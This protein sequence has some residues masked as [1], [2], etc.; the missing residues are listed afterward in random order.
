MSP[1]HTYHTCAN[2]C[3]LHQTQL[4]KTTHNFCVESFQ[5]SS[6]MNLNSPN[7]AL[8][9]GNLIVRIKY[10]LFTYICTGTN[11]FGSIVGSDCPMPCHIICPP[12]YSRR[13]RFDSL[14]IIIINITILYTTAIETSKLR[15]K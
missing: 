6:G 10:G 9:R 15:P 2:F 7:M 4:Q 14:T 1:V 8:L 13:L 5:V 3:F 11:V 12:V